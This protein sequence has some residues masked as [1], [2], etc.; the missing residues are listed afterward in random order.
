[1]Q[2]VLGPV[3][4]QAA[5]VVQFVQR[6]SKLGGAAF[7]QTL[8]FGWL[9]HAAATLDELCQTAATRGVAITPQGLDQR[10]TPAAAACVRTVLDQAVTEVI[11]AEPAVIP[12]LQRFQGVYIHDSTV[13]ALPNDLLTEWR[14]CGGS[15]D[16]G[17]AAVKL[18]VR[19][20]LTTGDLAGPYLSDGRSQDRGSALHAAP[21]PVGSLLLRDLG[22]WDLADL[23]ARHQAGGCWLSRVMPGTILYETAD[24]RWE[25]SK[26]L[27][28]QRET[29]I[30]MPIY[31]GAAARIPAR[32]LAVRVPAAVANQR[33]RAIRKAARRKGQTASQSALVLA[34]WYV[35]VT[36]VPP[37]QLTLTEA[38]VL[39]R[40]RWQI[41]LLFKL[42]KS[43]GLVDEWRTRNP[44]RILCEVYAKLLGVIIQHWILLVSCW[45]YPNRSLFKAVHTIHRHALHLA[46]VFD[47]HDRLCE[48]LTVVQRCLTIGCRI[49]KRKTDP[50][51]YQLLLEPS[52]LQWEV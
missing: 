41:E 30:E 5:R 13:I 25:V 17:Q 11:T 31:L 12:L 38:L 50:N 27:R 9:S 6:E 16:A 40:A 14:G 19:L 26:F 39:A 48:A 20:E 21:L 44:W 28:R 15:G 34:D 2:Y 52:L 43:K 51:T 46:S 4:T 10:F 45:Q 42:W 23:Q 47:Q 37:D 7:V 1:M 3:A 35:L 33:R 8:V 32:L 22:Y 49:N 24:Q 36:N 18:Q 29:R